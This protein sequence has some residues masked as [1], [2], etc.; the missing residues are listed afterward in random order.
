MYLCIY[1]FMYLLFVMLLCCY[2][3]MLLFVICN[4]LFII[5][6]ADVHYVSSR[7]GKD[8]SSESHI[9]QRGQIEGLPG[10]S[11]CCQTYCKVEE[12]KENGI[13]GESR[14]GELMTQT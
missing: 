8:Q 5:Y 9:Y 13:E 6:F 10:G 11:I 1:V 14:R 7:R 4:L 3:V 12:E 2:V